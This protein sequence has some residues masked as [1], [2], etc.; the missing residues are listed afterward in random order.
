MDNSVIAIDFQQGL[1][2]AWSSVAQ[3]VPKAVAFIAILLVGWI[4]AKVVAK[5]V[6]AVLERVGFD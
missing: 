3:F 4:I 2:D 5:I 1:T 6:N